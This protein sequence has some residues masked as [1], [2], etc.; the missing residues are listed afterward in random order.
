[1][2]VRLQVTPPPP[3]ESRVEEAGSLGAAVA[4]LAAP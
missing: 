4:V 1:M 2:E 3:I